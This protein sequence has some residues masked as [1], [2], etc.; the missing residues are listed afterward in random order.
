MDLRTFTPLWAFEAGDDT[1]ASITVDVE[2]DAPVLYTGCEVDKTGPKGKTHL[3]RISG[4]TG[5]QDWDAT[6]ACLGSSGPPKKI[7]AGVFATNAVGTG[8]VADLVFFT[9]ARCPGPANGVLLALDKKTGKEV[10]KV[11]LP[12]YSWSSPTLLHDED[13]KSWVLQGSIGGWL[14]LFDARTGTEQAR[15]RLKGDIEATPAAFGDRIVLGTRDDIIFGVKVVG[16][17]TPAEHTAQVRG[18]GHRP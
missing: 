14:Q 11:D 17:A 13:G 4:L 16:G 10:W 12:N 15:T 8:D 6:Y 1:D 7:D 5:K 18:A 9:L 3:R 2:G